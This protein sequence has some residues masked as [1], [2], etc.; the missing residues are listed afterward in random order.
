V[1]ETR[2]VSTRSELRERLARVAKALG[3]AIGRVV[4]VGGCAPAADDLPD[5]AGDVRPTEDVDLLVDASS[6][7]E[8]EQFV[9]SRWDHRPFLDRR[10][11]SQLSFLPARKEWRSARSSKSWSP[12]R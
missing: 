9:R 12:T 11:D 10:P 2:A 3:P 5:V 8:L 1:G 6:R 4:L 7:L